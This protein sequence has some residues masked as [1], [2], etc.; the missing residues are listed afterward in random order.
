MTEILVRNFKR[1]ARADLHVSGI[2]LVAGPNEAGKSS[3]AQAIRG[4]ITGTAIPVESE[5]KRL[6]KKDTAPKL[7]RKGEETG[8]VTIIGENG[9]VSMAWPKCE[10]VSEGKAPPQSSRAAAGLVS[11]AR[12]REDERAKYLVETL[13]A[14]PTRKHLVEEIERAGIDRAELAAKAVWEVIEKDG[15]DAAYARARERGAKLK[16]QWEEVAREPWGA[17]KARDWKPQGWDPR[18]DD[19]TIETAKAGL[20]AIEDELAEFDRN[21]GAESAVHA[22]LRAD[23]DQLEI[24]EKTPAKD[25]EE[26]KKRLEEARKERDGLPPAHT[27]GDPVECIKCGHP[28]LAVKDGLRTKLVERAEL[29]DDEKAARRAA[30]EAA[31]KKLASLN[32]EYRDAYNY[33]ADLGRRR[34]KAAQAKLKLAELT[35]GR[36]EADLKKREEII[37]RLNRAS[38]N[39][40][41]VERR[42]RCR[43]L[44]RQIEDSAKLI[45][46]LA[47]DGLRREVAVKALA[48]FNARLAELSAAMGVHA[49]QI[50]DDMS[51]VQVTEEGET[52]PYEVA[53]SESQKFR[54]RIVLQVATALVD[55]S[56]LVVI[57]N[58]VD[59]DRKFLAGTLRLL[60]KAGIKAVVTVRA[61]RPQEAPK[62]LPPGIEGSVWWIG[63]DGVVSPLAD[64]LNPQRQAAE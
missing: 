34:D 49:V 44:Q 55:G 21:A 63:A 62:G 28:Q 50:L 10:F 24:L 57:D 31:D 32:D 33:N 12:M 4:A 47:P 26:I 11:F 19:I 15:W 9:K 42:A 58:D 22:Q 46:I 48:D 56:D 59:Q 35:K 3:L 8:S 38:Y 60:A 16:G 6:T 7:V 37:Q 43:V 2:A 5:G 20:E 29:A 52:I 36:G 14:Y 30:I 23:A 45:A 27:A 64:I 25:L 54:T 53:M 41:L 61:D 51:V 13:K 40:G 1:I 18:F 39:V 17:E